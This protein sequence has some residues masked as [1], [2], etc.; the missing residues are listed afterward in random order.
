MNDKHLVPET[1]YAVV[2]W[3]TNQPPEKLPAKLRNV[4]LTLALYFNVSTGR[5]YPAKETIAQRSGLDSTT[6]KNHLHQLADLGIISIEERWQG[7]KQL[8]NLYV[9]QHLPE[10]MKDFQGVENALPREEEGVQNPPLN[11]FTS[12]STY[13]SY[14]DLGVQIPPPSP[15]KSHPRR[16]NPNTPIR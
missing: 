5:A 12:I 6:V 10:A 8:S 1:Y 14:N 16:R 13:K 7:K 11:R 2:N 9:F 15:S 3:T 4:F